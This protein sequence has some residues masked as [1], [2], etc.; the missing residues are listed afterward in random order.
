[1]LYGLRRPQRLWLTRPHAG[2]LRQQFERPAAN[3]LAAARQQPSAIGRKTNGPA[4]RFGQ[5]GRRSAGGPLPEVNA[6]ENRSG[7]DSPIAAKCPGQ[8]GIA[9]AIQG[10][11]PTLLA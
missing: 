8:R 6:V 4:I 5:E 1:M 9:S 3:P 2:A 10:D 7:Q 11:A